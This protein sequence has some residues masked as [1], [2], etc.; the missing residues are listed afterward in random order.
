MRWVVLRL[1]AIFACAAAVAV[2]WSAQAVEH[3]PFTMTGGALTVQAA[4]NG[5]AVPMLVDLGAGDQ[6]SLSALRYSRDQHLRKIRH[7][8]LNGPAG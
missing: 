2:P 8:E 7:A 5:Q 3:I 6:R 1:T 4:V